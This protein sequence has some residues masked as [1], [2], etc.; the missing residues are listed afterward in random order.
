MS[1]AHHILSRSV[2]DYL[3]AIY[4]LQETGSVPGTR[5]LAERL[6]T[7]AAA[8]S[9]MM[10]HLAGRGLVTLR[11]Y[12]G[13]ELTPEGRSAAVQMVRHHRLLEAWLFSAMGFGRDEVHE[14][15]ERLE[16][17][18]SERLEERMAEMLGNPSHDPH[19]HPIPAKDG[20]MPGRPG[21]ALTGFKR[22]D[23]VVVRSVDDAVPSL[24][25]RLERAG[26]A[27]GARARVSG[28]GGHGPMILETGCGRVTLRPEEAEIILA[29][30]VPE[31]DP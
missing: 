20:S 2:Q 31:D 27:P 8:V 28:G 12:R 19:G 26:V 17:H 13:F 1:D 6:G 22:G 7:S 23:A 9:K 16:H 21:R 14:E 15:A 30:A 24:L 25:R 11:P 3:K 29:E 10:R 18:I 5:K 4:R